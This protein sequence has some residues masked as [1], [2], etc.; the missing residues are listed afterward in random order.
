[1]ASSDSSDSE[2]GTS[3]PRSFSPL[4]AGSPHR[5]RGEKIEELLK[6]VATPAPEKLTYTKEDLAALGISLS[7]SSSPHI[8]DEMKFFQPIGAANLAR[9]NV[10]EDWWEEDDEQPWENGKTIGS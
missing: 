1:M 4:S 3:F 10:G 5:K 6:T 2:H 9:F 7:F 8:A